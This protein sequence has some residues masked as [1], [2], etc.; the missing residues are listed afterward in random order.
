MTSKKSKVT[1][2]LF[3]ILVVCSSLNLCDA[4]QCYDDCLKNECAGRWFHIVCRTG[5]FVG[6]TGDLRGSLFPI[7]FS[8][9][10]FH[11]SRNLWFQAYN[12]SY[13]QTARKVH[14][15]FDV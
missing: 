15:S 9:S 6:C 5:C 13:Y 12:V 11:P 7:S 3:V 14:N 1:F 8:F 2:V 10:F 4:D